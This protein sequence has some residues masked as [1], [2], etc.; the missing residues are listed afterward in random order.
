MM[1]FLVSQSTKRAKLYLIYMNVII[2]FYK[3]LTITNY[4]KLDFVIFKLKPSFNLFRVQTTQVNTYLAD[5]TLS[6]GASNVDIRVF[7][8]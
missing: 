1:F 7:K 3:H 6:G 8:L 2:L 4:Y 5:A